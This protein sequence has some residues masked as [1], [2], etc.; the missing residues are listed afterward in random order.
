M[1]LL[2]KK[3]G[4]HIAAFLIFIVLCTIYFLPQV[5]GKKLRQSDVTHYLG[6]SQE[7]REFKEETGQTSLWTNSMFGGMPTYQINT[8]K[9]GNNLTYLDS[10]FRLNLGSD[11]PIGRFFTAMIGFYILLVVLGVNP[12]LSIA[13]AIA[14]GFSTNNFILFEAGH[15]TKFKTITF[16]PFMIAGM[17]L[18]FREK[19]LWGG[20]LFAVGT[21]LSIM[22]NHVQMNYILFLTLL[23]F[24]VAQLIQD[25][26]LKRLNTFLK[27]SATL[28]VAGVLALGSTASNLLVTYEYSEDTMRGAPILVN[29]T[30]DENSSSE[31]EGLAWN[32]AMQW[33]NGTMDVF[34]SFI[35]GIVGGGGGERVGTSSPVFND[36]S[37][38]PYLQA[39]GM[40]APLYWG[41][42]PFTSGP[43]YFGSIVFLFFLMGLWLVKG[44]VKWWLG[45]GTLLTFMF[46]MGYNLEGFNRFFF[47][48][49]PLFNKF[50]T[51]NSVLTVTA[52]LMPLLG[53]LAIGQIFNREN[54]KEEV[55]KA[56]YIGGGISAAI[57]LFF[58]V[59][60]PG[61]FSFSAPGDRGLAQYGIT[62]LD[63]LYETRKA[64]MRSDSFRSLAI[65]L[66]SGG[67]IWAYIT[68][69]I[70]RNIALAGIVAVV[71]I[72]LW[73]VGNRYL[74]YDSFLP[75]TQ[76]TRIA[77][78]AADEQLLKDN[79]PNFRVY[80]A[81][82]GGNPF[83]SSRASYFHKS[84]GGYHA[85]KL[86]RYQDL[87][88]RHFSRGNQKVF[89][90]LNTKYFIMPP[91][92][93]GQPVPQRNPG[94]LG[95]AWLVDT[96][97]TVKTPNEEI[98][99]LTNFDPARAIV[100]HQEFNDYLGNI[101]PT[102]QGSIELLSYQ[103]NK[104]VYKSSASSEQLAVFSEIWYGP[105]KGWEASI[106]GNPVD[107]IRANYLLRAMKIPAG[108]HEIEFVF[109]PKTYY[110][111]RTIST[112]SS[113]FIL[114]AFLGAIGYFGY[115]AYK[116]MQN[117]PLPPPQ[118]KPKT[119][120]PKKTTAKRTKKKKV[121]TSKAKK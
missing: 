45:L 84:L 39:T 114:L 93:G 22:S 54:K 31:T 18:A 37:W 64:L 32:Y 23:V 62:N 7:V 92:G 77:A 89:D 40:R 14:F 69:R 1:N 76:A 10:W 53:F 66:V 91:Q 111:G 96:V 82:T 98:D 121:G 20:V 56:L 60:G 58:I 15:L 110:L 13:G 86:Q 115:D 72:D 101:Q 117:Q 68:D 107:H 65:A 42:L 21:G 16:F 95:N 17:L 67:I 120:I 119:R 12:W 85:A 6:M 44:P 118:D 27:A 108:D 83:E 94:A 46:S 2:L 105:D 81:S 73:P 24:G 113:S 34:A 11:Q 5:E 38:R 79:D 90:M 30:P 106:D 70:N 26:Q 116:N 78:N 25:I 104:L 4:P 8:V 74:S 103:P 55:L 36:K 100:V 51:P 112:I 3:I 49:V 35:P 43:I 80:D 48:Y 28:L 41:N 9:A 75:A 109:N 61:S 19:Y 33:S 50:R 59:L 99:A 87:I 88:D 57:Y 29:D 97:I 102:G 71:L 63:S 47:D 52:F